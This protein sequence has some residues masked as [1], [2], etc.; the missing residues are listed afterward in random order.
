MSKKKKIMLIVGVVVLLG[1]FAL[2]LYINREKS[3][4]HFIQF[5]F[6]RTSLRTDK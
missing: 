2:A 5:N 1:I 3:R 6:T 4:I